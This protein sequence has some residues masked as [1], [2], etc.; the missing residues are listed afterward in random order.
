M[1]VN[2]EVIYNS[3]AFEFYKEEKNIRFVKSKNEKFIYAVALEWPGETLLLES[4]NPDEGTDIKLLGYD[5]PLKWEMDGNNKFVIYL[6]EELQ[7][8]ENRPCKYA[9]VFRMEKNF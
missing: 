4:V 7:E 1:D 2:S 3:G 9:W 5:I 6:P 8:Q